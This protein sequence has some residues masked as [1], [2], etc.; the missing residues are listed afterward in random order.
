V[1]EPDRVASQD[2]S[3]TQYIKCVY[4]LTMAGTGSNAR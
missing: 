1:G 3:Q 2:L 4:A